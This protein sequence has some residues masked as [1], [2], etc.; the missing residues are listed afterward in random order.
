MLYFPSLLHYVVPRSQNYIFYYITKP[1][2]KLLRGTASL[3]VRGFSNWHLHVLQHTV[4]WSLKNVHVC[5]LFLMYVKWRAGSRPHAYDGSSSIPSLCTIPITHING[6]YIFFVMQKRMEGGRVI[7]EFHKLGK[8]M[9][10]GNGACARDSRM[11][12]LVCVQ[13]TF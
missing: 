11:C 3:Q 5:A 1:L 8:I 2:I 4:I 6:S 7:D 13:I 10:H 9:C 12:N